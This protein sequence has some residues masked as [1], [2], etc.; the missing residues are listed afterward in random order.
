MF[1]TTCLHACCVDCPLLVRVHLSW[2]SKEKEESAGR[3]GC[4]KAGGLGIVEGEG[5]A[6]RMSKGISGE[7]GEHG[8]DTEAENSRLGLSGGNGWEEVLPTHLY[9]D[10]YRG[11]SCM[12]EPGRD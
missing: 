4:G 12:L 6:W 3:I 2:I 11:S 8:K 9:G 5:M 7:R 10:L 1:L